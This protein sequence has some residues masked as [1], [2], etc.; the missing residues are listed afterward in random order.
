VGMPCLRREGVLLWPKSELIVSA[1]GRKITSGEC[2]ELRGPGTG[3]SPGLPQ[4]KLLQ[5]RLSGYADV[6]TAMEVAIARSIVR[7]RSDA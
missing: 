2:T 7:K 4:Q 6:T 5:G 3:W 1:G